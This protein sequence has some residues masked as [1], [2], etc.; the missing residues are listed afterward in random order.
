MRDDSESCF[1]QSPKRGSIGT[2]Y[3]G[4]SLTVVVV[5]GKEGV[6]FMMKYESELRQILRKEG[7]AF[8]TSQGRLEDQQSSNGNQH[9]ES[10]RLSFFEASTPQLLES[11]ALEIGMDGI[12]VRAS[13]DGCWSADETSIS[14]CTTVT[15]SP[16]SCSSVY[17]IIQD[18]GDVRQERNKSWAPFERHLAG[19]KR[20]TLHHASRYV[21]ATPAGKVRERH[22]SRWEF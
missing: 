10:K 1:E 19:S 7:L 21:Q 8:S 22:L 6:V 9:S 3:I 5:D 11:D 17:P 12:D 14:N 20:R 16:N 4:E 13:I 18:I 2:G 15:Y